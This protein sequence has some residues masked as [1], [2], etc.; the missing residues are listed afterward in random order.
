HRLSC[1]HVEYDGTGV[2]AQCCAIMSGPPAT[3]CAHEAW[4]NPLDV[5]RAAI[6]IVHPC[7]VGN[8]VRRRARRI[9]DYHYIAVYPGVLIS[10]WNE[11]GPRSIASSLHLE[12][13][14]VR[15]PRIRLYPDYAEDSG[16][17]RS[18]DPLFVPVV[19]GDPQILAEP[20]GSET[21]LAVVSSRD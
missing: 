2:A 1:L 21:V 10:E 11:L 19:E 3:V 9:S 14:N 12:E 18:V 4:S 20:S 7:L 17:G 16:N 8:D 13:R 5:V 15:L 6:N